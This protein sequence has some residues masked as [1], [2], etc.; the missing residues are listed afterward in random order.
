MSKIVL[1]EAVET[2]FGTLVFEKL[3]KEQL[4]GYSMHQELNNFRQPEKQ[5]IALGFIAV[6]PEGMVFITRLNQTIIG[7]VTFH[8]PD[9]YSRWRKHPAVLELGGIEV[10]NSF[11]QHRVASKLL[12]F[13]FGSGLMEKNIVITTEY[14]R[15][16]DIQGN[17]LDIWEYRKMLDRLFGK[18]GFIAKPTDDPD[19]LEHPANVLMARYGSKVTSD[20]LILFEQLTFSKIML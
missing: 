3:A 12:K 16:W 1:P 4:T 6:L 5:K 14:F 2:M 11:R 13:A 7:Y 20:D 8:Y 15:H 10:A 19:I 18:V 17:Q 9:E